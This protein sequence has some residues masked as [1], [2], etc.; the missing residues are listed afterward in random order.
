[1]DSESRSHDQLDEL[2]LLRRRVAELEGRELDRDRFGAEAELFRHLVEHSLGLMC[3]HDL[4]GKL[5]FVNTAAAQTL[6][7]RPEDGV[8]WN[9]RRFLPPSVEGQF[10]AY[11]ERIRSHGVDSG[12]MR[13]VAKD[14]TER[15]WL[16]RNVLYEEP[17]KPPRVLGHAQDV[18]DRIRAEGALRESEQR[19]R[20]LADTAPV[21]IWMSD[22]SGACAFLNQ[23][24]LDFTGQTLAEQ[25]G[26]GW[27]ESIHPEDRGRFGDA[28]R[29]AVVAHTAFQAEFRL[30]RADG[31]YRWV[32]GHGVPRIEAN[33]AFAGLIGSCVDVT[34]IRRARE[35][36]EA[37]RDEL[38]V[39]VAQRTAELERSNEQLRAEMRYRA[40]IEEEVARARR[41]ESVGVLAGGI[42][43]EFNN[44]L[45]VIIG[46]SQLLLDRF[47]PDPRTCHDVNVIQRTAQRAAAL[48]QQLLA[49]SRKQRLQPRLLN[50]NRLVAG[51]SLSSVIGPRVELALHA[52][53]A[54]WSASVDPVQ[55]KRAIFQ[56]IENACDAMPDGGQLVLE[57]AN[58]DLDEAFVQTH[59]GARP[60]PYVRLTLRDTG[61]G[62]DEA[63]RSRIFE[64]F[65]SAKPGVPGSGLGLPAVYGITKQHGGYIAVESELG[66]G[67]AFT[68]YLPA[69]G[70]VSP[71][72][73]G[74]PS[75]G[76]SVPGGGETILLV[77]DAEVVRHLLREI[78]ELHGYHV[79][80]VEDLDEALS[81]VERRS[82]PLHLVLT[83]VGMPRMSGPALAARLAVIR[84][85]VK[86]LYM[87]GH[88]AE[89]LRQQGVLSPGVA[90]LEKPFT[91]AS[92]L[93]KV[94]DVLDG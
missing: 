59:P 1:M 92:L 93:G 56:L 11:L 23:A 94:R 64:P 46:R 90:L 3:V 50:L 78:L 85:G 25:R 67:T 14:G 30:R 55:L 71:A 41:I 36:L 5:L 2:E 8:G 13:V 28:Y 58:V 15:I 49:F 53:D 80:E 76:P 74:M 83:D 81:L 19:F 29:A 54:L 24:W 75:T 70:E 6:G 42:A 88:S 33:D 61:P 22:P 51:L 4:E 69:A 84:P 34:E 57:T 68:I 60:G 72:A 31:E 82:G 45:T 73:V 21:L 62:M 39:L 17:G 79:I 38:T 44:L 66:H 86:A 65:F 35:V 18:T 47:R 37:A 87:S 48:T 40:Q 20:L 89:G 9:L 32:L 10:D 27:I 16:Y 77:E 63:T 7:F 52:E 12:L 26:A 91:L 43:H